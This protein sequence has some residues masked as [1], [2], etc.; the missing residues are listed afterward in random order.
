MRRSCQSERGRALNGGQGGSACYYYPEQV[1]HLHLS[2]TACADGLVIVTTD[3][4]PKPKELRLLSTV[5]KTHIPTTTHRYLRTWCLPCCHTRRQDSDAPRRWGRTHVGGT[6]GRFLEAICVRHIA[7]K[8]VVARGTWA[9]WR[10][11]ACVWDACGC[12]RRSQMLRIRASV[13]TVGAPH[14]RRLL[15][16][17]F[18]LSR[19]RR[20][21][22]DPGHL[23]DP[24][25]EL[26][27]V[28]LSHRPAALPSNFYTQVEIKTYRYGLERGQHSLN[29]T[30]SATRP[31]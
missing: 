6:G 2:Y 8:N 13:A 1:Q 19:L 4:E 31:I 22:D 3:Q 14:T 23:V 11:L 17:L 7:Q 27:R 21:R 24:P 26:E 9:F 25:W 5:T 12:A 16:G 10:A 20:R 30:T 29:P 15:G 28:K 18:E